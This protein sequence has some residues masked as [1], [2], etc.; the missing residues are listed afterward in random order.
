MPAAA[1]AADEVGNEGSCA[2]HILPE[3]VS[4]W[5]QWYQDKISITSYCCNQTS[6]GGGR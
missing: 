6:V 3:A 1:L 4:L 2:H 5:H